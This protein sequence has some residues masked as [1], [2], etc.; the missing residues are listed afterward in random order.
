MIYILFHAKKVNPF[1]PCMDGL[2]A[3]YAAKL[4]AEEREHDFEL[5]PAVYGEPPKLSLKEGDMIYLLDLTYPGPVLMEWSETTQVI[6]LD[7]HKG[8]MN[9][10]QGLSTA[11]LTEFDM[12]RSGAV[13]AWEHFHD[14]PIPEL[15]KYVQD[16]D[17][18]RKELPSCDLVSLGLSEYLY[19][20]TLEECMIE[21]E[22]LLRLGNPIKALRTIGEYVQGEVDAAIVHACTTYQEKSVLGYTV[23]FFVCRT[24]RE[25]QAYSDIGN[26]LATLRPD[27]PFAVVQ[28]GDGWAL[29]SNGFDVSLAAKILGGGGHQC[30]S[31][32]KAELPYWIVNLGV[33]TFIPDPSESPSQP[34]LD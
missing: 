23:P 6:V 32:T 29:R 10:L 17:L 4:W 22:S 13:I 18:W 34:S 33:Q 31:G 2:F 8:A 5:V 16:R 12:N 1:R 19:E 27:L 11:I 26:A 25:F 15:F 24:Q 20:L 3:A 30:A 9:D 7:H 28:T 21:I 14:T